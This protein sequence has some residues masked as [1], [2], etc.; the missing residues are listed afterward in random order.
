MADPIKEFWSGKLEKVKD[1]LTSNNFNAFVADNEKDA[2]DIVTKT[3]I[4]KISPDSV[5]WGGSLTFKESGLYDILKKDKNLK[6]LDTYDHS[7]SKEDALERRRQALLTDLFITGT[8]AVVENGVLVNLDMIGNRVGAITFGPKNV[9]IL[10]GRNKIVSDID[11]AVKRI[12]KY[13]APVNTR[14]LDKK[15]PCAK[16]S[17]CSDCRSPERICNTWVITEKSF[18]EKRINI[19]LINKDLGF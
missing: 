16:T 15:T 12:K 10:C 4:P 1:N 14:R 13:T 7:I 8:N 2:V 6:V 17:E 18:P 5:S 11:A 19:I 3:I 9:I